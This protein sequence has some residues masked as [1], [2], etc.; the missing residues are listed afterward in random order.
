GHD[1]KP[2]QYI[3]IRT[4]ITARK[5]AERSLEIAL[6]NDFTTTV[7]NLQNGIFK[8]TLNENNQIAFTLFEGKIT[9]KLGVSK[10]TL[11]EYRDLGDDSPFNNHQVRRHLL[12]GW[13]GHA[14]Q[15]EIEYNGHTFLVYLSPI[16]EGQSVT[17]VVGT[18]IDITE[19]K[20]A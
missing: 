7:K 3:S 17:E 4:D 1:G 12:R 2:Y 9:E 20:E 15:F 5:K 13:L 8:Y 10:E 14:I 11:N 18:A 6:K 16:W 19:R